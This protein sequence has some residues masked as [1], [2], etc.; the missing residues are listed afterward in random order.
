MTI[1]PIIMW[2]AKYIHNKWKAI[3]ISIWIKRYYKMWLVYKMLL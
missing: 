3:Y 2:W 1:T